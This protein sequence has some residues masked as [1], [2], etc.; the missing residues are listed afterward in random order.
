MLN[1][2]KNKESMTITAE[3]GTSVKPL[4]L[5]PAGILALAVTV[6]AMGCGQSDADPKQRSQAALEQLLSCTLQQ[7]EE[8][9][10]AMEEAS[11]DAAADNSVGLYPDDGILRDY[12]IKYYG[13]S[14]TDACIED[15]A[16]NRLI[17]RSTALTKDLCSDLE[18]REIELTKRAVEQECYDFSAELKTSA[19]EPAAKASGTISMEKDGDE[20]KASYITLTVDEL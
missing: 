2:R 1:F 7:A 6:S 8:F 13:N 16:M 4:R 12:L 20:W 10:A 18:A 9:D 3:K 14:M 11:I 19:G 17:Y 5:I 15:L